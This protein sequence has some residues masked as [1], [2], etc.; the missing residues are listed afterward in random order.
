M[1]IET[2]AKSE[3]YNETHKIEFHCIVRFIFTN[4]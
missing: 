1:T 4:N 2:T 3:R